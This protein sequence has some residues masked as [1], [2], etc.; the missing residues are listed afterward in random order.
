MTYK[1]I[2]DDTAKIPENE[3][4]EKKVKVTTLNIEVSVTIECKMSVTGTV[5]FWLSRACN[6]LPAKCPEVTLAPLCSILRSISQT[7]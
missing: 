6:K 7:K 1:S 5:E 4:T 3:H 2:N